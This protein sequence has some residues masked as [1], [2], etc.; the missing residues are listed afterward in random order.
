MEASEQT[1]RPQ[2]WVRRLKN[3]GGEYRHPAALAAAESLFRRAEDHGILLSIGGGPN[4]PHPRLI[5]LNMAPLENVDVIADAYRT[6]FSDGSID[7]IYCEAVLEHLEHPDRAVGEMVRLLKDG[8]EIFAA[9]PFL[10]QFHGYPS[11]YQ[12]FTLIGHRRLF[13]R[14]GLTVLDSGVCT[15]PAY[16]VSVLLTHFALNYAPTR[17]L[18]LALAGFVR[19]LFL[20]LRPLDLLLN[21]HPDAHI[22]ASQTF[23]YA[24][25]SNP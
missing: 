24:R 3:L 21:R 20:A 25:K 4:R 16:A 1:P 5:N 18:R 7:G 9:T 6:P 2:S 13:E 17:P 15:G 22:L 10:Q 11:H 8:G 23:V 14:A 12:N 19:V